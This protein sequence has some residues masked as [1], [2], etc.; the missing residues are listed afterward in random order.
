MDFQI[1]LMVI[2][3]VLTLSAHSS[4]QNNPG[5]NGCMLKAFGEN[6]YV[7]VC[8][9]TFCDRVENTDPQKAS[10]GGYSMYQ[11]DI[12]GKR[13]LHSYGSATK[14][15]RGLEVLVN[16]NTTFQSIIGFGGA[17]TDAAGINIQSLSASTQRNLLASYYSTEGIEYT[18]GRI[19]MASCDF[20]THP[21][22]YDD[23]NGD[24]NLTKFSLTEEDKKFKIPIIQAVMRTYK[25]NLT[26]FASPWSAPAWMKTNKNMT[27]KGA[28][29]GEPGGPY[30][31]TWAMYF[32]KFLKAYAKEG[33]PIWGVTGQNEPTD[34]FFTNFSF[35][36]MGWTPEMQRDFIVKD[37]GPA[38]QQNSLGHVKIMILDDSRLQLP[39]WAEQVFSSEEA[40][41]YVSGVAV[42]WYEDFITPA[43][44]LS[45]THKKFPEKF[46][47]ATEACSGSMPWDIPKVSLGSWKRGEDY[48]HDIIQDLNNFVSGWTDWNIALNM[49]G[50]PNWVKNFVDSPVIVNAK[51]DEFYKQPMFYA[52]GH[53][54]KFILPMSKRVELV[55]SQ[56]L[57]K[58]V[59]IVGFQ[60]PDKAIVCILLN[61]SNGNITLALRDPSTGYINTDLTPHTIQTV[62]WWPS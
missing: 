53:F 24:F 20:S 38:L 50:G 13:L 32:V 33:I 35:Q 55:P 22:S 57:P 19:P 45:S 40:R 21:Y 34:G 58:N 61:R 52:L 3:C 62:L 2:G 8:N 15:A 31:K 12:T 4:N 56:N 17:F 7:C 59:Y 48:A 26:L 25:R 6:A 14:Q 28:L 10:K 18:L 42:H 9:S 27:G 41:K 16:L 5:S 49:E 30:F 43:G 54:S 44:A 36:A 1:V 29:V 37:L 11:S 60:R 46:L 51:A 39:Y 47:L 23:N